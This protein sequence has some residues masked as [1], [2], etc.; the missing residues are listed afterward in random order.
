MYSRYTYTDS[1]DDSDRFRIRVARPDATFS[2]PNGSTS[3]ATGW[4]APSIHDANLTNSSP[5]G[6]YE[7]TQLPNSSYSNTDNESQVSWQL[8]IGTRYHLQLDMGDHSSDFEVF[9]EPRTEDNGAS[10]NTEYSSSDT[11]SYVELMTTND[12]Q[13]NQFNH[14]FTIRRDGFII[15]EQDPGS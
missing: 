5:S 12:N 11:L 7:E 9:L 14:F 4:F 1:T 15:W 6:T 2:T 10:W 3:D 8:N 13:S